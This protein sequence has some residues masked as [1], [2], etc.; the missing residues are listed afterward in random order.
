MQQLLLQLAPPP[1][2]TLD[3]FVPGRNAA[4]LQ[5]LRDIAGGSAGE[6]FVYLWGEPGSGRTHLLR[7]LAQ[8]ARARQALYLDGAPQGELADDS[9]I[10]IDEVQRLA[11]GDQIRLFDLYNRVRAGSGAL[12]ASGDAAPAQL[13]LRAD[14]GSRLAWGLAFQLHPLSDAE[15]AAAL[16]AHA[17]A[18]SLALGEDVIAYLLQHAPRDMA[19][20]IG[21]LDALDRHSLE[22][23]RPI[24]LPLV[25]NA[26]DSMKQG[27]A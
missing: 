21:I 20:L 23:K 4:A 16:R 24:T 22:Q 5:A 9:V 10:A 3:N 2:P 13:A 18:R 19:S 25:R 6:R 12:V 15:K 7:G 26:L 8:A 17:Q 14:L 27:F 1:A 11:A